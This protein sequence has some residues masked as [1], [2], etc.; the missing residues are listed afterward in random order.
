MLDIR[1]IAKRRSRRSISLITASRQRERPSAIRD[2]QA[3]LA[4][5]DDPERAAAEL[6]ALE[7]RT[8]PLVTSNGGVRGG[9]LP[10]D[11]E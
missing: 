3:D 1:R 5:A 8:G 10:S 2:R 9:D 7:R 6:D 4:E 11:G